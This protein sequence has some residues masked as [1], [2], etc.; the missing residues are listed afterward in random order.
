MIT[1]L[2]RCCGLLAAAFLAGCSIPRVDITGQVLPLTADARSRLGKIGIVPGSATNVALAKPPSRMNSTL[3]G[4]GGGALAV[5]E[6]VRPNDGLTLILAAGIA[7]I[8][9]PVGGAIGYFQ[10]MP[11][12]EIKAGEQV[13]RNAI[14]E[15][16]VEELVCVRMLQNLTNSPYQVMLI[17]NSSAQLETSQINTVMDTSLLTIG[18][19]GESAR[20]APLRAWM[21][22]RV[23][24][25]RTADGVEL[26]TE[27]FLIESGELTFTEWSENN[28]S[29]LR[30]ELDTGAKFLA[31]EI[32]QSIFYGRKPAPKIRVD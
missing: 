8:G 2:A 16:R 20:K 17:T 23:R 30:R 27:D 12:G 21:S 28:A 1:P 10:G 22:C 14:A 19:K 7:V 4:M 6:V 31:S 3:A 24:L 32:T 11:V 29:A 25:V 18:L 13:M 15:M 5:T 26:F 9:V